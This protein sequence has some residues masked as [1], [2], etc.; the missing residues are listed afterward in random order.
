VFNIL[1]SAKPRTIA[2]AA[3]I[4]LS[5]S[6]TIFSFA[7][8]SVAARRTGAVLS[9]LQLGVLQPSESRAATTKAAGVTMVMLEAQWRDMQPVA[10]A[11]LD[12]TAVA[13]LRQRYATFQRAGLKVIFSP[14]LQD[15]PSWIFDVDPDTRFVD[16]YGVKWSGGPGEDVPDAVWN[17]KVR[18]A[19]QAYLQLLKTALSGL[20][21]AG[22]RAGGLLNGE[23]RYPDQ[24][25]PR[26]SF[27]AF[28][29]WAQA[30]NPVL[31]WKPGTGDPV[32][33]QKFINWYLD[34]LVD[35]QRFIVA[36]TQSLVPGAPV[37]V[38]YPNVGLRPGEAEAAAAAG[39][40]GGTPAENNNT[41]SQGLDWARQVAALPKR[42]MF[43]VQTSIDR[44]GTGT[45]AQ[46]ESPVAYMSRLTKLAGVG[47]AGENGGNNTPAELDRAYAN[48]RT[49]K[50]SMMFVMNEADLY[51]GRQ[52]RP[53]LS[54]LSAL[55]A[56]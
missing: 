17:P 1:Q 48:A 49:Y 39:L 38:L 27:W 25:L 28:G 51:S 29:K 42:G 40:A 18:A 9:Q 44:T 3:A 8:P 55:Q 35:Y 56:R 16:Q 26:H 53:S 24:A 7:P 54:Q 45:T 30:S 14:G 23:L 33:A 2:R 50:L 4:I 12:S 52:D 36:Q 13:A 6:M 46:T 32:K 37:L 22:V 20:T 47:I 34:S 31:G 19:Q 5:T 15:A 10:G 41:L 21:F 43:A 11:G